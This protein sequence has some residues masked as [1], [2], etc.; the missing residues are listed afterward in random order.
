MKKIL[1]LALSLYTLNV[2]AQK[3]PAIT[4]YVSGSISVSPGSLSFKE[5][6]YPSIETGICYK[7]LTTGVVIGRSSLDKMDFKNMFWEWKVSPSIDMGA[8]SGYLVLGY[9]G[10]MDVNKY[11]LE[12]GTGVYC[13]VK[14]VSYFVQ[15]TNWDEI[16]YFSAG[17]TYNFKFKRNV[18]NN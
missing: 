16:N 6:S 3:E 10:Y 15:I 13:L 2:F 14:N 7:N 5:R 12:Y 1:F 18:R 9:G 11:F 8:V 17:L 4:G